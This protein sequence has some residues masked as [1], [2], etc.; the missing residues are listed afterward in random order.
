MAENE[1]VETAATEETT[2]AETVVDQENTS[3]E[4]ET[5]EPVNV[6][7]EERK[8][9]YVRF[10]KVV[11]ERNEAREREAEKDRRI[12]ELEARNGDTSDDDDSANDSRAQAR[13]MIEEDARAMIEREFGMPISE[14]KQRIAATDNYGQDY[15]ERQWTEK[16]AKAGLDPHNEDMQAFVGGL[17]NYQK[18]TLDVALERAAKTFGQSKKTT[19][20]ASV[21][22]GGV[23]GTMTKSDQV[24][25]DR[26]SA[27]EAAKK[28]IKAP[29]IDIMDIIA[30]R[31]AKPS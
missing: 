9:P 6:A 21:E 20:T 5:T 28:G 7:E 15:A 31:G 14:V 3:A 12:A 4:T 19:P 26:K 11:R 27:S 22:N 23:A 10:N 18:V 1:V 2:Q 30:K 17:V 25:W 13:K 8:I 29:M 24:F 16:C